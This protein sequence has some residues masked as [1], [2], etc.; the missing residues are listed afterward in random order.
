MIELQRVDVGVDVGD[1]V[2]FLVSN[3]FPF[4]VGERLTR[5]DVSERFS[6]ESW[7][8]AWW[9]VDA[10]GD[11][12]GIARLDDV[13]EDIGPSE[14]PMLDLRLRNDARGR[15]LGKHALQALTERV[16]TSLPVQRFE[17]CTR[18][19][20]IAMR[21]VFRACGWVKEAHY[22]EAWPVQGGRSLDAVAFAI[23][24]RDWATGTTTPV[25]FDDE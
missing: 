6:I 7:F 9:I 23:L 21:R 5:Q 22:R 10:Q 12:L 2:D 24:R 14:T 15:G 11:R 3:D 16:F 8:H 25:R 20:N 1:V 18:E 4:H 17:G 19:D 13:D